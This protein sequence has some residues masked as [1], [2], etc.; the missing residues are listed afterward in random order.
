M[1]PCPTYDRQHEADRSRRHD[2]VWVWSRDCVVVQPSP[3]HDTVWVERWRERCRVQR[4]VQHDT[5]YRERE[6]I[7]PSPPERY[8]PPFYKGCAWIA[9]AA[10]LLL[11]ARIGI[12]LLR[13]R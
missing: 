13:R 5:V 10:C 7:R 9:A 6:V 4:V 3:R 11:A 1:L 8:V 2:S 12:W